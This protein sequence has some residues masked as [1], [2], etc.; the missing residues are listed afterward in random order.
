MIFPHSS[1]QI[2]SV[3]EVNSA[4]R[5]LIEDSVDTLWVRG[6]VG[7]WKRY[8]SG[9]CYFSIKDDRSE[10]R[11]VMFARD[12]RALPADPENGMEVILMSQLWDMMES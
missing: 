5:R 6:E 11:C 7:N 9:H 3:S 10:L 1:E 4:I 2:W 8:P 12:A